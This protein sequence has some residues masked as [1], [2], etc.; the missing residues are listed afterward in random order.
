M[1]EWTGISLQ[2]QRLVF[3]GRHLEDHKT[4]SDYKVYED[5]TIGVV[6]VRGP[7]ENP[8]KLKDGWSKVMSVLEIDHFGYLLAKL[9][10]EFRDEKGP[11][12]EVMHSHLVLL[13]SQ[14]IQYVFERWRNH[15]VFSTDIDREEMKGHITQGTANL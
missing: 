9:I 15:L 11:E 7:G 2:H 14:I 10:N 12:E 6:R 3:A 1:Y 13:T 8:V 5:C 4:L